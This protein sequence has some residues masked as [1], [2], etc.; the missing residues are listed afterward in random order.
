MPI[1]NIKQSKMRSVQVVRKESQSAEAVP[2]FLRNAQ[3]EEFC[4][5]YIIYYNIRMSS[6]IKKFLNGW[7]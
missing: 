5:I 2:S 6:L 1:I 7:E 3:R 4:K